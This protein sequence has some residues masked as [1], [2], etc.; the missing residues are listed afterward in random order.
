[1]RADEADLHRTLRLEA[2]KESPRAFGDTLATLQ[3]KR[4]HYWN[5]LTQRVCTVDV[6]LLA[7]DSERAIGM[8]YGLRDPL[9]RK[10]ARLGGIWVDAQH[11][12][13]GAGRMLVAGVIGWA[14]TRGYQTARLWVGQEEEAAIALY[15]RSGFGFTGAERPLEDRPSIV[16][17]EMQRAL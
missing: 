4:A 13:R 7:L 12:R 17:R 14:Q 6:M 2:L 1:L 8:I 15:E 16:I 10:G 11:R 5:A 9:I 3:S